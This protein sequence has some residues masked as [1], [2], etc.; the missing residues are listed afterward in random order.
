VEARR[1]GTIKFKLICDQTCQGYLEQ[2]RRGLYPVTTVSHVWTHIQASGFKARRVAKRALRG[3]PC[4]FLCLDFESPTSRSGS[5]SKY[6]I[7]LLSHRHTYHLA[8]KLWAKSFLWWALWS[9][10][11]SL[12]L[13]I[14]LDCSAIYLYGHSL[15]TTCLCHTTLQSGPATGSDF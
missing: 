7:M 11:P 4:L 5:R 9:I 14:V 6:G 15:C 2:H 10:S 12:R 13:D 3:L 1:R 8:L